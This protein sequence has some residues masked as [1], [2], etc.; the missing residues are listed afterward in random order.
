MVQ[1]SNIFYV[2]MMSYLLGN[3]NDENRALN[4]F[5]FA[6]KSLTQLHPDKKF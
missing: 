5:M 6:K 4:S 3:V 1:L 2:L